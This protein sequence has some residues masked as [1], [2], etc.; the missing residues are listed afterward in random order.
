MTDCTTLVSP[1]RLAVSAVVLGLLFTAPLT[2]SAQT[3]APAAVAAPVQDEAAAFK[4]W[5]KGVYDEGLKRGLKQATLDAALSGITP[6]KRVVQ[7][8]R[9]Q[10]EF[11]QT[12]RQY[13][14]AR[15]SAWRV[16]TGRE[17]YREHRALLTRIGAQFGVQPRFIVALWGIETSFGRATGSFSVVQ[18]LATLAF[19]GR[20]SAYFR[21]ELFNALKIIDEG[22]ISATSMKGSWAG[23]MGQNQFMPSSFLSYAVDFDGDGRRDIWT[24]QADVFASSANYLKKSGWRDDQ[25]W[26]REV[27]LPDGLKAEINTVMPK[28]Q[29]RGCRAERKLSVAKTL[30]QWAA[31]GVTNPNGTPLPK[32]PLS[33]QLALPE[34][35]NGPAL[36]VY[37]NFRA[38]LRWNC[39]LLFAAAVG[40][41]ADR[42]R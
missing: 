37:R 19:D 5:L 24:T 16:R 41:L 26:G 22:H 14:N 18:A 3:T 34:G 1:F 39:S 12:F 33:A 28:D 38:T 42:L 10:P 6:I 7:L 13:I 32:R 40:I 9:K 11:T 2:V 21:R 36:L 4:V 27:K 15:V 29:P 35:P 30:P 23:A 17:R 31:L 8:D 25:T 20:R